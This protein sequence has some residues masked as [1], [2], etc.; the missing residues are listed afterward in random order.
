ML[1]VHVVKCN[2]KLTKLREINAFWAIFGQ[3]RNETLFVVRQVSRGCRL[4]LVA[5]MVER[6]LS[7]REVPGSLPGISIILV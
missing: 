3:I 6:P 7:M 4:Q 1:Q 2:L 5:Q